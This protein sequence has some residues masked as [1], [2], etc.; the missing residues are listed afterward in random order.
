MEFKQIHLQGHDW[1][2]SRSEAPIKPVQLDVHPHHSTKKSNSGQTIRGIERQLRQGA[3]HSRRWAPCKPLWSALVPI[4]GRHVLPRPIRTDVGC[5]RWR[6]QKHD[7]ATFAPYEVVLQSL[8]RVEADHA[9][10]ADRCRNMLPEWVR[11]PVP[12][13]PVCGQR[14]WV[15]ELFATC[16]ALQAQMHAGVRLLQ[17]LPADCCRH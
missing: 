8:W 11:I 17:Q 16:W 1:R 5:W 13:G 10:G 6:H 3:W 9:A 15:L 7:G 12:L 14:R 2:T 4:S